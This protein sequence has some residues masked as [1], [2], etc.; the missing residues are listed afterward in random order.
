MRKKRPINKNFN[1]SVDVLGTHDHGI[2]FSVTCVTVTKKITPRF[3]GHSCIAP[4]LLLL[5]I[6]RKFCTYLNISSKLDMDLWQTDREWRYRMKTISLWPS[7]QLQQVFRIWT[8]SAP[9][10]TLWNLSSEFNYFYIIFSSYSVRKEQRWAS[11]IRD[12]L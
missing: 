9:V 2:F 1:F 3:K 11:E 5:K 6:L 4:K 8:E 10:L 7:R 12:L